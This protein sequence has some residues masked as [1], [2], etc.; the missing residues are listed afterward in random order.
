MG[1]FDLF[2]KK[3][4]DMS[5]SN[6]ASIT[7]KVSIN[8]EREIHPVNLKKLPNG[9]LPGEV[10][11]L[12]WIEDKMLNANFPG[13]FE[14]TYGI[15]AE[16][17]A[18]LVLEEGYLRYSTPIESLSSLKVPAL[19][20]ILKS[21]NLKVS[22]AKKEL[23][24]RIETNFSSDEV[25][26]HIDNPSLKLTSKGEEV[27]KEYYYIVP[28]HKNGSDDGIYNVA[29]AIKYVKTKD[30]RPNNG[31][32]SWA[33]F[34]NA[35]E[36][37]HK[38][39]NYGLT[40]KTIM[41][42]ARQLQREKKHQDALFHYLRVF[43]YDL[44]GLGNGR[45]LEDPEYTTVPLGI[46]RIIENLKVSLELNEDQ[47][48][49]KFNQAWSIARQ[50]LPF[51]YLDEETTFQCLLACLAEQPDYVQEILRQS[52]SLLDKDDFEKTYNIS[53]PPSFFVK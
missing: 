44:S 19:K 6:S 23:I 38:N 9:L 26:N 45:Y 49:E 30:Y 35:Y 43:I 31:D 40:R 34:Q 36:I 17:S 27:F 1:F 18:Q 16:K 11:L 41:N 2:K 48:R 8:F 28:A 47:L 52:F 13:Y 25:S 51:H 21:K 7:P 50:E 20:E 22:G 39:E 10:I 33:L 29:E 4:A 15:N 5:V 42:M 3:S 46:S 14:Y 12:D 32:I 53:F 24:N 37:N